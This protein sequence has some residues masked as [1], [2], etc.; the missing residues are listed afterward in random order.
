MKTA[1]IIGG[2]F[3]GCA[4]AHQ[5]ALKGGW[6]VTLVESAPFLGAGVRTQF[7][8]GHPYTFGPRHFL[9][10]NEKVYAF[11]DKYLPLRACEHVFLTYVEGDGEFYNYPIHRDDIPRMPEAERIQTELRE[12]TADA[13]R[14]ASNLEEYWIAS[15][16]RTLYDKFID[17][18]SKK[19]WMVDDNRRIDDF[20][21][22]PKGVA[23]KEGPVKAAWSEALSAYPYAHDGYNAYFD[24]ATVGTRVLL[25]ASIER[26]DIPNKRVLLNGEWRNYDII[27]NTI[28]PDLLFEQCF[29][30]LPYVGRDF[31]KFVLPIEHAFPEDV[32]FLYYAGS[33]Q[34]TRLVEYK[35]FT[36]HQS[37]YTVIGMEIPSKNGRHYP[38]PFKSEYERAGKY[39]AL[40]PDGV[41][42][43][44]RAGS[45][46]YRV[47]IDDCIEQ[48]MDIGAKL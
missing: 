47:D 20:G 39:L 42:S 12:V 37:P 16:G 34:F 8:G 24:L 43:I 25:N 29:G 6:D 40:L 21:W 46:L 15:V 38:L 32:Y 17:T 26:Y 27:V 23:L 2:G 30:E 33:E 7:Y 11:L 10:R 14:N 1:L 48:A 5:F 31:H 19:M 18:Y 44:G 45:Y 9:T 13:I 35:K 3:A 4:A 36:R 28:S 41:F 22:S